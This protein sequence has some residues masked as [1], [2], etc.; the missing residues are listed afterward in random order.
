MI[1]KT[2]K[3]CVKMYNLMLYDNIEI[4]FLKERNG[5]ART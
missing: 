4:L 2:H 3:T 5:S 1:S